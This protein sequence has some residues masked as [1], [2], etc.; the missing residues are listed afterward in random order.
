MADHLRVA[1]P[2]A[3]L[4]LAV[5]A[6]RPR[7]GGLVQHRDRGSQDT[8]GAYQAVLPAPGS[9]CSLRRTGACLDNALAE[10]CFAP[11]KRELLPEEGWPTKADARAAVFAWSA[12]YDHRQRRHSRLAYRT[13]L[14]FDSSKEQASA[15]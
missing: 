1:L 11:L 13:P 4:Q 15:A 5:R 8:A 2:L 7:R 14:D 3:A 9:R 10:R 12:V 6:R